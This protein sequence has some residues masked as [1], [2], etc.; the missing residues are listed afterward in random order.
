M[1]KRRVAIT[2]ALVIAGASFVGPVS[3]AQ[4]DSGATF[5]VN[6]ASSAGCSDSTTDS[7]TA[8]YCTIQ[9]AVDAA[10]SPGDTVIVEQ[11]NYAPF[12]VTSSGTAAAPITIRAFAPL[13]IDSG[14]GESIIDSSGTT[15]P[16]TI[17]GANYVNV[18]GFFATA[19]DGTSNSAA[20]EVIGSTHV[21]VDGVEAEQ[22]YAGAST[23][24]S[25]D[26]S[27]SN[28]TIS[29]SI[30][31]SLYGSA[32]AISAGSADDVITTSLL[33]SP[34][35]VGVAVDG[36]VGV[37]V[38]SNT[39]RSACGHGIVFSGASTSGSIENNELENLYDSTTNTGCSV[40]A[41]SASGIEVDDTAVSGTI[42]DYNIV[43]LTLS[44]ADSA[45]DWSGTSYSNAS[46]LF[47]ATAEGQHDLNPTTAAATSMEA[48]DSAN[49]S[50]SGELDTDLYGNPRVDDPNVANT[51]SGAST[52]YDR[53]ATET[54][55]TVTLGSFTESATQAPVGG[56]ITF[57]ASATDSWS[58]ALSYEFVFGDGTRISSPTG[59][60]TK[61]FSSTGWNSA[62]VYVHWG[63]TGLESAA[64]EQ[65]SVL[66]VN[67]EPLTPDLELDF[68][69][70]LG[71]S[72][73]GALS[74]DAWDITNYSYDFGDGSTGTGATATHVYAKSGTYPV[75]L[76]VT[77]AGGNTATVT[78]SYGTGSYF[79]AISPLR[80]LDSRTGF[81]VNTGK[82][83][84]NGTVR[85]KVAGIE[86]IPDTGVTAVAMNVTVTNPDKAGYIT[87]YPDGTG[88]PATSNINFATG[89][90]IPN[91]VVVQV[92]SDGYVD[93]ANTSSGATDLVA[94]V[95]GYYS[96]AAGSGFKVVT[97][98]RILDTR[99]TKNTLAAGATVRVNLGSYSGI[100]AA[101]LNVTVT[102]PTRAGFITAYPDGVT[103]PTASNVNYGAGQTTA[104]ET[105]VQAGSDGY[106]DFTNT[107]TGSVDLVLDLTGYFTSAAGATFTPIAP[108]R[109]SQT[110]ISKDTTIAVSTMASLGVPTLQN[111]AIAA[112]ITVT[113]PIAAGFI[114]AYPDGAGLPNASLLNFAPGQTKANATMVGTGDG[115]IDLYNASRGTTVVIVDLYGYYN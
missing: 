81:G 6:S 5:Y 55:G 36:A 34:S 110:T 82:V 41:S 30:L 29:R 45:Y 67:P 48:I 42:L 13:A 85:I 99:T 108:I 66:V 79:T 102:D 97:P 86:P 37:D 23:A 57:T 47:G 33:K 91:M 65:L 49:S 115:A 11:G 39:I 16:I 15:S 113:Q 35:N 62:T 75:T 83:S 38:T 59:T 101:A 76:T 26:G 105:V 46:A 44:A 58:Q 77:D 106:V 80:I 24:L 69:Q 27:S 78:K 74:A 12:A 68:T 1:R 19:I 89:Q 51:G 32:L 31:V 53:G 21:G 73:S 14:Y 40:P 94:D 71:V 3:A 72:A 96:H 28:V 4:A 107:S 92:G 25:I 93:L 84:A 52:Y 10:T 88:K 2:S 61:T 112:N 87:A 54:Q 7:V 95:A 114:T 20:V 60:V 103:L 56:A 111:A 17:S 104:N 22:E 43:A 64:S 9:A 50:A 98:T 100:T 90:T 109:W 8:P 70:G 63:A 18:D